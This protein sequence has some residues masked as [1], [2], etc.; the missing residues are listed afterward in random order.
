MRSLSVV[1]PYHHRDA[2]PIATTIAGVVD[3]AVVYLDG[4]DA[5]A[6]GGYARSGFGSGIHGAFGC[7]GFNTDSP[8]GPLAGLSTSR[9]VTPVIEAHRPSPAAEV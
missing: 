6:L 2:E 8:L 4:L 3:V 1:S 7:P 5:G 9:P